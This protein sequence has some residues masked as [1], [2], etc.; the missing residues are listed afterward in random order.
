MKVI[1]VN[2]KIWVASLIALLGVLASTPSLALSLNIGNFFQT[3]ISDAQD[4]IRE[5]EQKAQTQID[6][7]WSGIR[8]DAQAAIDSAIGSMGAVDPIASS[9]DL[10]ERLRASR[11]LP[12]AKATGQELERQLTK[13]SVSAVM[14]KE[15][16]SNT[17]RKLA[18][19]MQ[20]AQDVKG[21]GDQAQAMDASQNILKAIA[22]QNALTISMLAQVGTDAETARLDTAQGNL[23]LS[24][25]ADNI[26][27]DRERENLR[28]MGLASLT[29]ELI[30]MS[31][32]D[33]AYIEK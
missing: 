29:Q 25:I 1:K 5:L 6:Q 11:S 20:I 31:N 33:P 14:S 9:E 21:L 23:M 19:T 8:T 15:G 32:L 7:A 22:A 10:K 17:A 18:T 3:I 16:Q 4:S 28:T 24:Q 12:E 27:S 2:Q 26:A 13:S 30:V